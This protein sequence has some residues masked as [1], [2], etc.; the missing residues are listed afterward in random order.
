MNTN[1]VIEETTYRIECDMLICN[2]EII[3]TEDAET[4]VQ[5]AIDSDWQINDWTAYCP[6]HRDIKE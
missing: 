2:E 6:E 5:V 1:A 3:V 4:C